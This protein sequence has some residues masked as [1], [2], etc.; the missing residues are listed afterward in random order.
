MPK[1]IAPDIVLV[2]RDQD[3]ATVT[4]NRPEKLNAITLEMWRRLGA[5]MRA[6]DKDKS[7]RCIVIRGAGTQAFAPGA[8]IGE[9][10]ET[11]SSRK[12][13]VAYGKIMHPALQ[14]ILTC[15]HPTIAMI[16]GLC[17]GGGLEIATMCDLRIAGDSAR[18]GLP[19]NRIGVVAAYPE[20]KVLVDL[21]GRATV[22]E[23]LLE[24]RVFGAA[25]AKEKGL[26]T[27]VVP[28]AKLEADVY[29]AARRIADGAPLSNQWHKKASLRVLDPK[30]ITR[31]EYLQG[32]ATCDSADYL[33]GYQAFLEKRKPNFKGQ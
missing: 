27:R 33:E 6:L 32:F 5:A 19:I 18:L 30:P 22:L 8:D 12:K 24:A 20:L 10:N 16:H 14:A 13:A 7:V 23:I 4:L 17:V 28:D 1:T 21:V 2:A 11:R 31:A 26:L 29:A 9:F 15:R 25:E 3:I